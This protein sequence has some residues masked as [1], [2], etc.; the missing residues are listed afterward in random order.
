MKIVNLNSTVPSN[1]KDDIGVKALNLTKLSKIE[2]VDVPN[3]FVIPISVL[4][5][6]GSGEL[7]ITDFSNSVLEMCTSYFGRSFSG[8]IAV[9]SSS[10]Y[11]DSEIKSYAGQFLSKLNVSQ[12]SL[13]NDIFEVYRSQQFIS[14]YTSEI[15]SEV[16]VI[17]QR[18]ILP[19]FS[20]VLFTKSPSDASEALIEYNNLFLDEFVSGN[21]NAAGRISIA[22]NDIK[23]LDE[24]NI[25]NQIFQI[26]SKLERELG[27]YCDIEWAVQ[28]SKIFIL[29]VRPI[30]TLG[31]IKLFLGYKKPFDHWTYGNVG[32]VLPGEMSILSWSMFG[33]MIN[34][35]L[36]KSFKFLSKSYNIDEICFIKLENFQLQYN[37]GAINYFTN[38]ILGFP[39]MDEIIGGNNTEWSKVDYSLDWKKI[40]KN[41]RVI[42]SNNKMFKNLPNESE[43]S[44]SR[45]EN[46]AKNYNSKNFSLYSTNQLVTEFFNI[47]NLITKE[48]FL[49]TEATS[50][51]FSMV[52]L[53][54]YLLQKKNL[55]DTLLM[56]L[57]SD[58]NGIK[59]AELIPRIKNL[60]NLVPNTEKSKICTILRQKNWSDL[61]SKEGYSELAEAIDDLLKDY[62]HRGSSE[63]ELSIP[64]WGE[65]PS[66]FLSLVV[67]L[68]KFDGINDDFDFDF[69]KVVENNVELSSQNKVYLFILKKVIEKARLFTRYRENNKHYLYLLVYQLRRIVSEFKNRLP[70]SYY[71]YFYDFTEDELINLV[72][73]NFY[74]DIEVIKTRVKQI[75]LERI[76]YSEKYSQNS[77]NL[78]GLA[79]SSGVVR[80]KVRV[81]DSIDNL[82]QI[83]ENEILVT[84]S[85]DIGWAPV[86]PL[87]KGLITEIGGV[88][89]HASIIARELG[90]PAIV[91]IEEATSLL[92]TGEEVV[93]DANSGII[94]R[95][96]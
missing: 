31:R 91:N 17:I 71:K 94:I 24:N 1:L 54:K 81:V 55:S 4:R 38:E 21:S 74:I 18:M 64:T 32:E 78:K 76:S 29:Q 42:L 27:Y 26:G 47:K 85:L 36:R 72:T 25:Y 39:K 70:E 43:K 96:L 57:L 2:Y 95:E 22:R 92:V 80:G 44:Y 82:G 41:F 13:I 37:L 62:G 89:S 3:G 40:F 75:K 65:N 83:N 58:I 51:S 52:S 14:G 68:W 19:D 8:S 48:M 86:F 69:V 30:T 45:I 23:D 49:H 46:F 59:I 77:S 11:E 73:N 12:D 67:Y 33:E 61:L 10:P 35:L 16:A 56:D 5:K 9:R 87:V 20:G 90:V 28:N 84:K 60:K 88:L 79:V 34:N 53:S 50:A 93:L 15:N 63:L 6:V 7:D 66:S